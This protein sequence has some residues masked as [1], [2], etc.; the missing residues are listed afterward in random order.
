MDKQQQFI[1][2]V[3]AIIET[4]ETY[5]AHA[6]EGHDFDMVIGGLIISNNEKENGI[7]NVS[8]KVIHLSNTFNM[9]SSVEFF[10]SVA[11]HLIAIGLEKALEQFHSKNTSNELLDKIIKNVEQEED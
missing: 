1:K 3:D 4:L 9:I 11:K 5:K 10:E 2:S 8:L 6:L 7:R